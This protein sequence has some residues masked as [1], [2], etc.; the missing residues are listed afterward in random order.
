[1]TDKPSH[2]D[3]WCYEHESSLAVVQGGDADCLRSPLPLARKKAKQ[4]T[5]V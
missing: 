3:D 4:Y 2:C 1:M 5:K